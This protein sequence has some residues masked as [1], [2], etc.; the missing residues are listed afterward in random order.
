LIRSF[1]LLLC[2]LTLVLG[3]TLSFAQAPAPVSAAA[4][5]LDGVRASI[6]QIELTL[7]RRELA[8]AAL[9]E[10][11]G[12]IEPLNSTL[13]TALDDL[14]PKLDAAREQ[15]EQ[16][17]PKPADKA[18]PE[19]PTVAAER[20]GLQKQFEEADA[21]VKR[22]KLLSVRLDQASATILSLRRD[23]FTR[24]LLARSDS[25]LSPSLW[26]SIW[27]EAPADLRALGTISGA[28]WSAAAAR[29]EGW[30]MLG[31]LGGTL[32]IALG[33]AAVLRLQRR[34]VRRDPTKLEV[35][36]FMKT[37]GAVWVAVSTAITPMIAMALLVGLWRGLG[38][39]NMRLDPLVA[40]LSD[41]VAR[42]AITLA[43]ARGLLAP[44]LPH[45]RLLDLSDKT[46]ERL[47]RLALTVAIFV[48]AAKVMEAVIEVIG[49]GLALSV[50]LR[51][52]AALIV[53]TMLALGMQGIAPPPDE[54]DECLGPKVAP[55]RDWYGP[56]R[57]A[58]WASVVA[59]ILATLIGYVS[60][61][62]FLVE[63]VV[64][65][66]FIGC[67]L[68]L[69]L[70]LT[71]EMIAES[72]Q[73]QAR[74]GRALMASLGLRREAL[75]QWSVL[76]AGAAQL[77]LI[78]AAVMLALAPW[79]V[80]SDDMF[81]SIRAAFFGFKVGDVT[82][83]LS[84]MIVSVL[85][86][87]I[88]FALTR[89][90]QHWLESTLLPRTQL[91]AG[92]RNS[93]RTSVGYIGFVIAAAVALG[94]MGLS[95]DKLAIV[96]GALSVGIG[97]GLQSIVNNFVSGLIL[98]WERA[99]RVGDWV[100]L[101][102]EQGY[103]RRIN[104]RSTEIETFDRATMIVP[105]SNL[106]TGVVKNWVRG[107]KTGRIKIP[108]TVHMSADPETVRDTLI[109]CAKANE[110]VLRIPAPFVFFAGMTETLLKFELMCFVAD[111]ETS[112]RV[113][114]DLHFDIFKRFKAAGLEFT[115]PAAAPPTIAIA[116][117][118]RLEAALGALPTAKS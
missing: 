10:L 69:L 43:I 9:L 15:L 66:S 18:P 70:G 61:A 50:A 84:G 21:A 56:M 104:V 107:D 78:T 53:A 72:L 19:A 94:Y 108:I 111:V 115:P 41:G 113:K 85:L 23:L 100:V 55:Q 106:V 73:P 91:D 65:V 11:R 38:L 45:W 77:G 35:S 92:L 28:W 39:F 83:S 105:N 62:A 54:E 118:E 75:D 20:E 13:K 32:A 48:S 25:I 16:L 76:L 17:G 8:D 6:E 58:I 101:G 30:A 22:A 34:V 5:K 81:S 40:S 33:W 44:G 59:I 3:A 49:A 88:G 14:T 109:A 36:A 80:E 112:G 51:G 68:Y 63:Q 90:F 82:I 110:L 47:A 98:L 2:A 117:L 67:G 89:G 71:R 103:V 29:L 7:G 79:G 60:F 24:T 12:N 31:F 99:I 96:A 1:R 97:F 93:I 37:R 52:L 42:V 74:V 57:L 102:E 116:G 4:Q 64:W 87:A 95:F 27:R 46:V 86:F 26:G 114:S